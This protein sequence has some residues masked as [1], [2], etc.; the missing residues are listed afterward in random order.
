MPEGPGQVR[1]VPRGAASAGVTRGMASGRAGALPAILS[2]RGFAMGFA[3]LTFV[4]CAVLRGVLVKVDHSLFSIDGAMQT[5]FALEGFASGGRLGHEFQSYLG[6][7]LILFLLPMYLVFGRTLF[8]SSLAANTAV[9]AGLVAALYAP[10]RLLRGI[11]PATLWLVVAALFSAYHA[12]LETGHSL[13]PLRWALPFLMFPLILPLLRRMARG[14]AA[15]PGML[16]GFVAGAGLLWSN[17]AGIPAVIA[18]GVA[19]LL[20]GRGGAPCAAVRVAGYGVGTVAAAAGILM[21]VTGGAPGGW[22]AYNFVAV[23]GDQI[24]YFGPW[25]RESRILTLW[26]LRHIPLEM[27]EFNLLVMVVLLVCLT[28]AILRLLR[29]RCAPARTAALV[30]LGLSCIGTAILPQIGGHIEA[31]Y[32]AGVV[33]IG[34]AAPILVWQRQLIRLLRRVPRRLRPGPGL[35]GAVAIVVTLAGLGF[36]ARHTA[37]V[38]ERTSVRIMVPELGFTVPPA[39]AGDAAALRRLGADLEAAGVPPDQR[40]LPTYTSAVD[41]LLGADRATPVGSIIHAL[42]P[43]EHD[44]FVGVVESRSVVFVTTIRPDFS[45]WSHWNLRADWEFFRALQLNYRPV[46]ANNQHILWQ[47]R[48]QPLPEPTALADC[49]VASLETGGLAIRVAGP[50]PDLLEVELPLT[51]PLTPGRGAIVVATERSPE[52]TAAPGEYW[53]EGAPPLYGARPGNPMRLAVPVS[54]EGPSR[55]RLEVLDGQVLQ[56][57][58]CTAT[59]RSWPSFDRLPSFAEFEAGFAGG[60]G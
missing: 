31:G 39:F 38:V 42:G 5:W 48:D 41:I 17:D 44:R 29:G 22:L 12:P 40:L 11:A 60:R 53:R 47:R 8:A 14:E 49:E 23:P 9:L 34:L 46:A 45:S 4:L 20:C 7:T 19:I 10:L 33:P 24:W 43:A 56:A 21:I 18:L 32:S 27:N 13:R 2:S 28:V 1:S 57:K 3:G 25:E 30:F 6:V 35:I 52:V 58:S 50:V 15:M 54:G 26:D 36:A 55:L 16:A 37:Q 59:R 51:A